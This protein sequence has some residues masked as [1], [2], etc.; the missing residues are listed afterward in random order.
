M[1]PRLS[2]LDLPGE[3]R[4]II[5]RHVLLSANP[6]IPDLPITGLPSNFFRTNKQIYHESRSIYYSQN[7]FDLLSLRPEAPLSFLTRIGPQNASWIEN[8][9]VPFPS[10]LQQ[11]EGEGEEVTIDSASAQILDK[12]QSAC[13]RLKTL[14]LCPGIGF[15]TAE[16]DPDAEFICQGDHHVKMMEMVA[17]RVRM[18]STEL[19]VE[20]RLYLSCDCVTQGDFKALLDEYGWKVNIIGEKFSHES[21]QYLESDSE[22]GPDYDDDEYNIENNSDY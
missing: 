21:D 19:E 10:F 8:L 12:V 17:S 15:R 5:Y 20:F 6:I 11:G 9:M 7:C 4:N 14:A 18:I 16:E 3:V 2:I 1:P 13:P 22:D